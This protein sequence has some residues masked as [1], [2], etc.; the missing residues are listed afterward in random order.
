MSGR[1]LINR[2]KEVVRFKSPGVYI[3]S[4]DGIHAH[5]VGKSDSDLVDRILKSATKAKGY[6]YFWFEYTNSVFES[7]NL[8]CYWFHKY[9]PTD[10][11]I[12]PAAPW[13]TNWRCYVCGR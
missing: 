11:S 8:E 3:L 4:R 1:Y 10:N 12:H 9:N 2:I 5:Y 13:G 6:R 7:Y